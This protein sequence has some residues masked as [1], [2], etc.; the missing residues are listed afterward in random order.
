MARY[1]NYFTE[2]PRYE[3]CMN[4]AVEGSSRCADHPIKKKR[5]TGDLTRAQKE[6]ARKAHHGT[7]AVPGCT[8]KAF[9]VDHIVELNEFSPERRWMA[10]LPSNLQLLCF[11]HHL[12]KTNEY[13]RSM[14]GIPDP[15][16]RSTSARNRK[17]LR[18]KARGF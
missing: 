15:N 14:V 8:R 16:D 3:R 4:L 9:E 1:C 5:R 10:N 7:C 12:L 11:E 17:K 18:R 6:A 2:T 13:R